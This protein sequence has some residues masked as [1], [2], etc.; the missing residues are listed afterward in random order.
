M[1]RMH[2]KCRNCEN[3]QGLI[4]CKLYTCQLKHDKRPDT[5][6]AEYEPIDKDLNL[7]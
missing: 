7:I 5:D 3:R 4:G 2:P 6:C 1:I